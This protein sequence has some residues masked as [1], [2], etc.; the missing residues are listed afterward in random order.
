MKDLLQHYAELM[1]AKRE[2]L[3][4]CEGMKKD[5]L[6]H[7]QDKRKTVLHKDYGNFVRVP[8]KTWHYSEVATLLEQQLKATQARE[9]TEGATYDTKDILLFKPKGTFATGIKIQDLVKY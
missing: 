8:M 4:E 5:I 9:Q 3:H 1:V 6:K 7:M 2:I